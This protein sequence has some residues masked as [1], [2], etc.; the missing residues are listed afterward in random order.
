M[1][2]LFYLHRFPAFG[3][4]EVVTAT[5]ANA[6]CQQGHRVAVVS[7]VKGEG[8]NDAQNL[9]DR[10]LLAMMPHEDF[11]SKA[12]QD[13]LQEF[14]CR[15]KI[16]LVIF[17]DSYAPIERNLFVAG[18][19]AR[20][21]TCEHNAP[22]RKLPD[23]F[24]HCRTIKDLIRSC[25]NILL[26]RRLMRWDCF[27][28][29]FLYEKSTRYVLLSDRYLGE[30]RALT[31]L[32]EAEKLRYI[33]NPLST[34]VVYPEQSKERIIVFCGALDDRKGCRV[35]IRFWRRLHLQFSNWSLIVLGDG[36][37]KQELQGASSS[38]P[39]ISFLGNVQNPGYWFAKSSII[40]APSFREGLPLV[41]MEASANGCVPIVYGS[42]SAAY[43]L[44]VNGKSGIVV[45]PFDEYCLFKS[46]VQLMSKDGWRYQMA[47]E[48][49]K[50]ALGSFDEKLIVSEWNNLFREV[51][52]ENI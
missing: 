9:D 6:F 46:L 32:Y 5:L 50:A 43:E 21:I 45:P 33:A 17:Q 30:F 1:N 38:L 4:I 47:E 12:N 28:R 25:R 52:F 26:K 51:L 11:Y 40:L 42:Y 22:L 23:S 13:F 19:R 2:I 27:R 48:G 35:V 49:R 7:H 16:D 3:G 41:L 39:R 8:Q 37:L 15:N 20:V 34:A 24:S 44:V 29:R 10:I 31:Q 18:L 36:P 14:I